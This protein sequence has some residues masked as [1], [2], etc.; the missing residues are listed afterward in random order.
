[1]W[2]WTIYCT[3]AWLW[4]LPDFPYTTIFLEPTKERCYQTAELFAAMR[5][6]RADKWAIRCN[7]MVM[8]GWAKRPKEEVP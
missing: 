1:M 8:D 3:T 4:C 2:S 5:Q 6:Y 7:Y